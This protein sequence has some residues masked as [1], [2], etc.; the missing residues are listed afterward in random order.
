MVPGRAMSA[1]ACESKSVVRFSG[2]D[3]PKLRQDIDL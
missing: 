2:L 3:G 1:R